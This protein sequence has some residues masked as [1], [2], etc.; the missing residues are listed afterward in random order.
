MTYARKVDQS[1]AEIVK[2]LR[3]AGYWVEV[4]RRPVDLVVG[5][6]KFNLKTEDFRSV[7]S[8]TLLEVKTPTNSGKRRN[9]TDQ[10]LQDQFIKETGTPVVM[11]LQ[12]ALEALKGL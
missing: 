5:L 1:Q 9:R 3:D 12:Q 11:T 6:K 7:Y 2:G 10:A 4:I 8:W